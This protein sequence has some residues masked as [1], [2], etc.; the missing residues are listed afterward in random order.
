ML[1]TLVVLLVAAAASD[2]PGTQVYGERV[3]QTAISGYR[4]N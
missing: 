1:R 3:L 2:Q 4:F